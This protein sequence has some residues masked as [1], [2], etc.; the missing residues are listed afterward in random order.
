MHKYSVAVLGA[1]GYSG[2]ELLRYIAGHPSIELAWATAD[3]NAGK[4]VGELF[5]HLG[6]LGDVVLQPADIDAVPEVD[7]AFL[8][9]PHG[10]AATHGRTLAGRG[11][12]VVD[13]SADWRLHDPSAYPEWYGAP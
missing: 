2:A 10:S 6:D 8:A 7:L 12:K 4:P 3:S 1:S 9:L 5:G 11:I 13:L